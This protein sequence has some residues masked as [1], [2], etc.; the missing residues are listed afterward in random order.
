MTIPETM[1]DVSPQWVEECVGWGKLKN[2][3]LSQ[4]V[5]GLA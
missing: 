3:N 5:K 4:W 2:I 1:A